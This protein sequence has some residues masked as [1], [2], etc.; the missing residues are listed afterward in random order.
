MLG[1]LVILSKVSLVS[2][3]LIIASIF[4]ATMALVLHV[5]DRYVRRTLAFL[6]H[7]VGWIERITLESNEHA[8]IQLDSIPWKTLPTSLSR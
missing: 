6:D 8:W 3:E 2:D 5:S 4:W 1:Q 7:V